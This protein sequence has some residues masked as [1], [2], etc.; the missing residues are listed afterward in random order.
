MVKVEDL[1]TP[2]WRLVKLDEKNVEVPANKKTP[3]LSVDAR[4]TAS[5]FSGC[6][7][8]LGE[9]VLDGKKHQFQIINM[10]STQ[11]LCLKNEIALENAIAETLYQ[12][13][14]IDINQGKLTL[15][16]KKHTLLFEAK[17]K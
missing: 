2:V 5:G 14:H 11:K 3:S 7:H 13:S 9:V 8:Y 10:N 6:N 15:K 12:P 4:M 17:H 1:Q 16:G